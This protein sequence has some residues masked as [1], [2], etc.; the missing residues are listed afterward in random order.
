MPQDGPGALSKRAVHRVCMCVRGLWDA[1]MRNGQVRIHPARDVH[2]TPGLLAAHHTHARVRKS[3]HH[4]AGRPRTCITQRTPRKASSWSSFTAT[5]CAR[6]RRTLSGCGPLNTCERALR[7]PSAGTPTCK[8]LV[9]HVLVGLRTQHTALAAAG[10]PVCAVCGH[11]WPGSCSVLLQTRAPPLNKGARAHDTRAHVC[12]ARAPRSAPGCA[13][14]RLEWLRACSSASASVCMRAVTQGWLLLTT[15]HGW[16]MFAV[17]HA[18]RSLR[19]RV[20]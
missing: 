11:I 13:P 17:G 1:E 7:I 19:P 6:G 20:G 15:A 5:V 4:E 16:L 9:L 8:G 3:T 12:V 10:R 2:A 14:P 18:A